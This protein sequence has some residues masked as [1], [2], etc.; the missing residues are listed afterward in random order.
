MNCRYNSMNVKRVLLGWSVA[1]IFIA[2]FTTG[3]TMKKDR[4]F[5][6]PKPAPLPKPV[7][8]YESQPGYQRLRATLV[9]YREVASKGGWP[10]IPDGP[11]LKR[12]D[13]GPRVAALRER[14]SL[15]GDHGVATCENPELF[16]EALDQA[17]KRFQSCHGLKADGIVSTLTRAELNVSVERRVEQLEINLQRWRSLPQDL[18]RRYILVNIPA[19]KLQVVEDK[20]PVLAMRVVVGKSNYPTPV[21]NAKMSHLFLNPYWNVPHDMAVHEMLP[22]IKSDP[23]YL[24][25]KNYRVLN[26]S[27]PGAREVDPK[28]ID[29]STITPDDFPYRLRQDP[30][31]FNGMGR[32]KFIFINK[33]DVYLHDTPG[34]HLFE[35]PQ[36]ALS[37]GCIRIQKPVDLAVYL[38][39]QDPRWNRDA[40]LRELEKKVNQSVMLPEQIPVYLVYWT[41]WADG[42]GTIQFCPDVY[43][44]D[45]PL[46]RAMRA[47]K[48]AGTQNS[49]PHGG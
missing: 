38:L 40:V 44:W 12:G 35:K 29:W 34:R 16:D 2:L 28:T 31:P 5:I 42:D 30:G 4:G 25:Q 47:T 23:S 19:F 49:S 22:R 24:A 27:G 46:L 41:V 15:G 1:V 3:C 37:H 32:V 20:T 26:G 39:R 13:N 33:Y 8:G 43:G 21:L 6:P 18:G 45:A 17:V 9:Q 48:E 36:R 14:L 11:T 10:T 7:A